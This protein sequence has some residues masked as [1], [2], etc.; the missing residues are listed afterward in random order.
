MTLTSCSGFNRVLQ[1]LRGAGLVGL[2]GGPL[3]LLNWKELKRV[4]DFVPTYLHLEN[5]EAA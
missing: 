5:R 3:A 1:E 4:G 2:E